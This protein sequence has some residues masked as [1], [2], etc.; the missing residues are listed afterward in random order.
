PAMGLVPS[1]L[2]ATANRYAYLPAIPL[3]ILLG[4]AVTKLRIRFPPLAV[5]AVLTLF[6]VLTYRQ[7]KYWRDSVALWT[8][9]VEVDARNDVALYNLAAGLADAGRRNEALERYE[10]VLRIVPDQMAAKRNRDLLRAA[11]LEEEGNNLAAS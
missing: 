7:T 10:D 6:A 3:A 1:G 4:A 11:G 2:Q 9:A 5:L 8:R